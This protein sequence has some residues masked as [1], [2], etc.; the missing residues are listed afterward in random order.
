MSRVQLRLPLL[1][2]RISPRL[3]ATS[4]Y[5]LPHQPGTAAAATPTVS[6]VDQLGLLSKL[7]KPEKPPKVGDTKIFYDTP[8]GKVTALVSLGDKFTSKPS[9]E[10][11]E[12]VRR[13]V[14]NAVKEIRNLDG[15][16]RAEIDA[17]TDPH[18]A[19]ESPPHIT[20]LTRHANHTTYLAVGAHLARYAFTLKTSPPSRFNPNLEEPIP[21]PLALEPLKSSKEWDTGVK[22]AEAQNW[23]K[24]VRISYF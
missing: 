4:A 6:G 13:A 12:L 16:N 10:K 24:T 22:Y 5:I 14:G 8:E 11:R 15:V 23:A 21:E 3:M 20:V 1:A 19:G 2:S 17:S 9:N 18:A 7:P